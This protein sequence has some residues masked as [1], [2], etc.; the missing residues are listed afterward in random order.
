[1]WVTGASSGIGKACAE[2]WAKERRQSGALFPQARRP[3]GCGPTASSEGCDVHVVT[4]DLADSDS[5]P[6]VAA[7]VESTHG[8]VDVMVHC[9]GISQRSKVLDTAP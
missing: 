3:G 4:L 6:G 9:G 8:P 5:L 1:M 2:A 7:H